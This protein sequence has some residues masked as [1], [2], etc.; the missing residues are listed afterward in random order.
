MLRKRGGNTFFLHDSLA[1]L[2]LCFHFFLLFYLF[3]TDD[4]D[5][6]IFSWEGN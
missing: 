5:F 4:T 3:G 2:A 6:A 1:L